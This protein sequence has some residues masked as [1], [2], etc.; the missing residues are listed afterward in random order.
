LKRGEGFTLIEMLTVLIVLAVTLTLTGFVFNRY[1]ERTSARRA[2]ELFG[3][4][5]KAARNTAIRSRQAVVVDFDE[6]RL[7]YVVRVEAG[8]TLFRRRFEADATLSLSGLDLQLSGD[9][10]AFNRRGI[11]DLRGA[12]G[13]VGRAVF[14]AGNSSYAVSFNS[15]GSSRVEGT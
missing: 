2:A 4:D 7:S 1:L 5:L 12:V 11:A 8:D 9:S 15:M 3:Q 14:T 10:V 6:T 13:A